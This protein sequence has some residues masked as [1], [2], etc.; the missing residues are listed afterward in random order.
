MMMITA[1]SCSRWARPS[2]GIHSGSMVT[3]HD[4][5]WGCGNVIQTAFATAVCASRHSATAT[6][7]DDTAIA[8]GACPSWRHVIRCNS[9]RPSDGRGRFGVLQCR[10]PLGTIRLR[11]GLLLTVANESKVGL[12][13]A[14][15]RAF[16]SGAV[17]RCT[18]VGH[19]QKAVVS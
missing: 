2:R 3:S 13:L 4:R 11:S 15:P 9:Q 1:R 10:K 12:R 17:R 6:H 16:R 14:A 5:Y 18:A 7:R 8:V 19:T